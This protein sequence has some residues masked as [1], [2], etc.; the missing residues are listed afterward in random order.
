MKEIKT[1]PFVPF[2]HPFVERLV[3]TVRREYLDQTP[4]WNA[5]DLEQKLDSFQEYYNRNRAHQGLSRN[6]F[7][8]RKLAAKSS[9]QF[10]SMTTAGSHTAARCSSYRWRLELEFAPHGRCGYDFRSQR[11]GL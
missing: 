2:S 7:L 4:V 9:P 6:K 5:R 10:A 3:G 11:H 1:V 8:I